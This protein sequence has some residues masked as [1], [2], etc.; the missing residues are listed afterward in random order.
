M[1]AMD[2]GV[3][4]LDRLILRALG[5][6]GALAERQALTGQVHVLLREL[7]HARLVGSVVSARHTPARRGGD[8]WEL[9]ITASTHSAMA[10]LRLLVPLLLVELQKDLVGLAHVSVTAQR[11]TQEAPRPVAGARPVPPPGAVARLRQFYA[12]DHS[13]DH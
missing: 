13:Q 10:K 4:M 1:R 3:Q 8:A 7:G 6:S 9:V 12:S 11:T 2:H 5:P